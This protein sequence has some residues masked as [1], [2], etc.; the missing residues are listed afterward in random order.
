MKCPQCKGNCPAQNAETLGTLSGQVIVRRRPCHA[1]G[2]VYTT[3]TFEKIVAKFKLTTKP[4]K[5]KIP[6]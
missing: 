1:C 5:P 4:H 2:I 3:H 6:I